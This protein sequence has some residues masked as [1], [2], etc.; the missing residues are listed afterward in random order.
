MSVGE[1]SSFAL[2][3]TKIVRNAARVLQL[4]VG[5]HQLFNGLKARPNKVI[6]NVLLI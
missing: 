5:K 1:G 4:S 2:P 3:I 6:A